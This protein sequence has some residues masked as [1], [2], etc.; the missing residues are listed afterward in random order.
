MAVPICSMASVDKDRGTDANVFPLLPVKAMHG[1]QAGNEERWLFPRLLS[2]M[3]PC[4][5]T[6]IRIIMLC[7]GGVFSRCPEAASLSAH[8]H[9]WE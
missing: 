1:K 5:I 7:D 2:F 4:P 6:G 9:L 8:K 3:L